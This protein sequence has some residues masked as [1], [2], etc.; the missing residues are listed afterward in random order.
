MGKTRLVHLGCRVPERL[1][2]RFAKLARLEQ[3]SQASY[4]RRKLEDIVKQEEARLAA[5][6]G[7]ANVA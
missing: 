3:R 5:A 2:R 1:H 4:L 7:E 6:A